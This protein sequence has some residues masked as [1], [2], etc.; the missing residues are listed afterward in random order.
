MGQRKALW[1]CHISPQDIALN[2]TDD[3]IDHLQGKLVS[4]KAALSKRIN[5][6]FRLPDGALAW[7]SLGG[8]YDIPPGRLDK[9]EEEIV[10]IVRTGAYLRPKLTAEDISDYAHST[11]F[12]RPVPH[13]P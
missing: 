13:R 4:Q 9:E 2:A 10:E 5:Y 11:E 6:T 1:L 8:G 3:R 12:I 7:R